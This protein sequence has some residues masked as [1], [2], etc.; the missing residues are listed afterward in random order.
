MLEYLDKEILLREM[1][2]LTTTT[3]NQRLKTIDDRGEG[4]PLS[5]LIEL[6]YLQLTGQVSQETAGKQFAKLLGKENAQRLVSPDPEERRRA[7][8][9]LIPSR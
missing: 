9:K 8:E 1:P 2:E 3:V 5:A 6:R 7:V 4:E